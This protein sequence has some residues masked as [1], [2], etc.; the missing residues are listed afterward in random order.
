MQFQDYLAAIIFGAIIGIVARVILPGRQSIGIILTT[1]IGMGAAVA[2]TWAADRWELSS[3][4]HFTAAGHTYDWLVVGVQVGIAVVGVGL[5][6]AITRV[7]RSDD[8]HHHSR[9]DYDR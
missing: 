5:A 2:G 7:F 9:Y 4:Y 3:K 6:A 1:L 8:H